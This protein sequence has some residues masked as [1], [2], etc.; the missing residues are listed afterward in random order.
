[1]HEVQSGQER[2]DYTGAVYGSLLAASVVA[3]TTPGKDPTPGV[4][5]SVL[6]L[7]TG[8]VFWFAHV[9]ARLVGERRYGE[10]LTWAH[11]RRVGRAERPLAEAALPPALVAVLCWAFGVSDTTT[12]WLTLVT[13]LAGQVVW[14]TVAG[15]R[16]NIGLHLVVASAVGNL[17]IGM[18]IVVLK[19]ALTH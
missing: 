17:L 8:L 3:G 18:M 16:A 14:A 10:R 6:I 12:G 2:V 1:M 5:V 4:I 11:T 19:V 9:Y 13:A 7:A 15:V